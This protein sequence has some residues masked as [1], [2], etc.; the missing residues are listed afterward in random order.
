MRQ[1]GKSA[2]FACNLDVT[3]FCR[4]LNSIRYKWIYIWS[5]SVRSSLGALWKPRARPWNKTQEELLFNRNK[6]WAGTLVPPPL[7]LV[8]EE[9]GGGEEWHTQYPWI[10]G[11]Q[12]SF[13]THLKKNQWPLDRQLMWSERQENLGSSH[14]AWFPPFLDRLHLHAFSH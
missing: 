4:A 5:V 3:C 11:T 13:S 7:L 10:L 12:A 6:P 9:E 14:L 2:S 8:M 1:Y